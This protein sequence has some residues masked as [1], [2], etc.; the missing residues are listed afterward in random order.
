LDGTTCNCGG[1]K[2]PWGTWISLEEIKDGQGI[3]ELD[4]F[5]RRP[6]TLT[7]LGERKPGLYESFGYDIRNSTNPKLFFTEDNVD[8]ALR[9]FALNPVS[10]TDDPNK[11]WRMLYDDGYKHE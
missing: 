3:W 8:G 6:S 7:A 1:G 9:R 11:M 5:Y 10:V 2:T 4:P